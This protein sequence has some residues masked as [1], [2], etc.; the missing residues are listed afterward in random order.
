MRDQ[1]MIDPSN[2]ERTPRGEE[3]LTR[4]KPFLL[5]WGCIEDGLTGVGHR[6]LR[7]HLGSIR[8]R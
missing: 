3:K 7:L 4:A 6:F 1:D 2:P 5:P 8:H